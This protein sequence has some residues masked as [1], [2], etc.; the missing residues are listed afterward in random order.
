MQDGHC[1]YCAA[2]LSATAWTVDHLIPLIRGGSDGPEN[3]VVACPS[4]NFRKADRTPEEFAAGI[5]HRR[6]MWRKGLLV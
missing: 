3:I 5:S 4:C 1:F 2:D 6:K